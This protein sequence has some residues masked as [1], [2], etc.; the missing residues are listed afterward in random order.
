MKLQTSQN[1]FIFPSHEMATYPHESL[2]IYIEFVLLGNIFQHFAI[3][4]SLSMSLD[5][6]GYVCPTSCKY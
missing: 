6:L 3:H 2:H 5:F 4:G 1:N